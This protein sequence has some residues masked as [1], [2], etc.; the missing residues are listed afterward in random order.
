[1]RKF[2][3]NLSIAALS[4]T[5]VGLLATTIAYKATHPY[6]L[7]FFN[8][9]S[10]MSEDNRSKMEQ[11]FNYKQFN[12][13]SEFENALINNKAAAGIG[14]DF[15]AANLVKK[16]RLQKIDYATLFDMPE[17]EH[18]QELK[19]TM[20]KLV[21]RKEVWD[22]MASY[23]EVLKTDYDG[24]EINAHLWEYFF[25]YYSQDTVIAYN[26]HKNPIS[27][28]KS[29]EDGSINLDHYKNN[30][31]FNGDGGV[32]TFINVLKI[33]HDNGFDNWIITD[34]IR[35]N[36]LYGSSY[37]LLANGS[38]TS[39]EFTGEVTNDT[40]KKLIDSFKSLIKDGTGFDVTNA[41]NISFEGDGLELL[42]NFIDHR[43]DDLNAS[44]MYNGDAIDA[45]YGSDNF[46][47]NNKVEDGEIRVIKPKQNLLLV[48]GFVL[49]SQN[50]DADN[51]LFVKAARN[52]FLNNFIA[53]NKEINDFNTQ[54]AISGVS[55]LT[56]VNK[57]LFNEFVISN[58]WKDLRFKSFD[59]LAEVEEN[60]TNDQLKESF[61]EKYT[62]LTNLSTAQNKKYFD[63]YYQAIAD[64]EKYLDGKMDQDV[65]ID[66]RI[67]IY[68]KIIKDYLENNFADLIQKLTNV[69]ENSE[70]DFEFKNSNEL[71][72]EI[73]V[74]EQI[75]KDNF[76]D[77]KKYIADNEIQTNEDKADFVAT[78]IARKISYLDLSD[79]DLNEGYGQLTN[80]NY[81]NY[82]PTQDIIYLLILRNYFADALEGQDANV[83]DI[84]EINNDKN[85]IHKALLP[86]NDQLSTDA[87]VY[88]YTQT[89]S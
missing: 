61:V 79:D 75:F 26:I 60:E 30:P 62:N 38:R 41:K 49:S 4:I 6:K 20:V 27:K 35:D 48:D 19:E 63:E 51:K 74:L 22:H 29:T 73:S 32:R 43:R 77:L 40:Y 71:E 53:L 88:Y 47:E 25:P 68:P 1:M 81:V 72:F 31:E 84:F 28:E 65:D 85:T 12:E 16:G 67:N 34:A 64:H 46:S 83:I 69:L 15:L 57:K 11:E 5:T 7:P 10:Y 8:F 17:L 18:N 39:D 76:D 59:S 82:V 44:I 21:L 54:H 50:T 80:F 24:K 33:L 13:I 56:D 55:G 78:F 58:V 42:N 87:S 52:S 37:W 14:T 23:D 66:T 86:I 36:M 45:Y 70:Y 2:L 89:K 9:K 3:R